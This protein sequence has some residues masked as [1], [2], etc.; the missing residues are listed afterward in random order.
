M[1]I[2]VRPR[3]VF[4]FKVIGRGMLRSLAHMPANSHIS[5]KI[6]KHS[7]SFAI[8]GPFWKSPQWGVGIR[9]WASLA[10]APPPFSSAP[11]H[12]QTVTYSRVGAVYR[13]VPNPLSLERSYIVGPNRR[14]KCPHI[15]SVA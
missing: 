1:E 6:Q 13:F 5:D 3:V 12:L 9:Q 10:T 8:K 2:I 15:F 11:L 7:T 4:A 14:Y